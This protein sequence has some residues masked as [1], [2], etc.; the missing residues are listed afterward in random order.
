MLRIGI[1]GLPN[2]GK[3]TLFNAV[4][5]AGAKVSN[6][7]F[8]TVDPNH[9]IVAVP[10]ARLEKLG[11]IFHQSKIVPAAME[12]V[13]IAGLVKGAS[14]GEGLGNQFLHHIREVDAILHV[15]R[16]FVCDEISHVDGEIDPV[17]D[18]E[19]INVEL[20]LADLAR[21]EK[22]LEEERPHARSGDKTAAKRIESL[23]K[24]HAALNE[25][26]PARSAP[27]KK[28]EWEEL[29]GL[30]LL[31][32]KP[33]LYLANIGEEEASHPLAESA[34]AL[35]EKSLQQQEEILVAMP[36]K[37]EADLAELTEEERREF[38]ADMGITPVV[39]EVI[40]ACYRLLGL[41][42][43]F[44]GVGAEVHAW[45]I[46]AGTRAQDAAGKIHSDMAKGFIRAEVIAFSE[47]ESFGSWEAA[48]EAGHIR[49]EGKDYP[50]QEGDVC[51]FRF[52]AA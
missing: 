13:D 4:S 45:A 25:G 27:L 46:P 30:N 20:A 14:R 12:F 29:E 16:C 3:S 21:V 41:I 42:T 50:V 23:E 1:V 22:R 32:C 6:Y 5:H 47:L 2:V 17:R 49:L 44:T 28:E 38:A 37:L 51:Y 52:H 31:T 19:V 7:P 26:R 8:C 15:V 36:A 9:G 40:K 34:A 24:I 33:I 11:E 48:R 18:I 10:D 39:G 43:F 35:L